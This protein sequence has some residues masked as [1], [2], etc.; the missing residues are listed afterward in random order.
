[1]IGRREFFKPF[2]KKEDREV[3][4]R[5]PYYKEMSLF[6]SGCLTCKGVCKT[7]CPEEIITIQNSKPVLVFKDSGCTY[8]DECANVC[9]FG[10]LN[11]EDKRLIEARVSL[12]V[13]ECL[14]WNQTM[15]FSCK[16]VCLDDAI[17]FL[18]MFR[19]EIVYE[20]CTN[21]GLCVSVCPVG[22]I[23]IEGVDSGG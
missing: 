14:S 15:C 23:E 10:V 19:A 6:E 13:I 1:M 16:D 7:C 8:C 9:E 22:A 12:S 17:E 11:I 2:S 5:P 20:K 21:C 3:V 18:G 4:I